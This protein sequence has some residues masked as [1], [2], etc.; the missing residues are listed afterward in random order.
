NSK[1]SNG[2]C[3]IS[4]SYRSHIEPVLTIT[5]RSAELPQ[6]FGA[7]T[8]L[9]AA[10]AQILKHELGLIT[11]KV[12]WFISSIRIRSRAANFYRLQVY[13]QPI[14]Y[15]HPEFHKHVQ[16]QWDKILADQEKKVS[17]SKL[18]KLQ[19]V[20]RKVVIV[21]EEDEVK[22]GVPEFISTLR[23]GWNA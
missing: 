14:T 6:I 5:S 3:L 22:T 4:L 11:L 2:P 17:F 8:L 21:K 15:N 20:Y 19:D 10:V 13:P 12:Q 7:D 16:K 9:I 23:K 18:V 1:H